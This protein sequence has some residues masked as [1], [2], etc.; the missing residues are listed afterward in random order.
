MDEFSNCPPENEREL[1]NLRHSSLRTTIERRF[2]V[3]KKCFQVLDA[4]LFWS[5]ETQV[6]VVLAY[7][8]IYNHII[9]VDPIDYFIEAAMNQLESSSGEPE[10]SSRRDST[11]ESKVWNVKRDEMCQAMWSDYTRGGE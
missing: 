11:E 6:E 2:G 1:F 5:F 4:K 10:T 3:L 7:C 9:G 8:M